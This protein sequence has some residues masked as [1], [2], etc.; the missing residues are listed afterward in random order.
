MAANTRESIAR[1]LRGWHDTCLRVAIWGRAGESTAFLQTHGV[2]AL[3]FPIMVDSD[4]ASA[5]TFV[6]GTSQAIRFRDWLLENP[7]DIIVIPCQWR[8]ADI[9]REIDAHGI[10]YEGILIPHDGRLVDF[11]AAEMVLA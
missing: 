8:A 4:P 1:E 3:R 11:H 7:V 5:G 6:P 10:T 9:V 2:D